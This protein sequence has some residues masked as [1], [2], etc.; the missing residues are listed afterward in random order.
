VI[1][2]PPGP[3]G[4][5]FLGIGVAFA[6]D[7]F[8]VLLDTV[9][10]YGDIAFVRAAGVPVY[11]LSHPSDIHAVLIEKHRLYNKD[12][13]ARN[14]IPVFGR[15]LLINEGDSWRRQRA[16]VVPAFHRQHIEK[17]AG[18]V[19]D[20]TERMLAGWRDGAV[21]AVDQAMM[22]LS[23]D[24]VLSTLFGGDASSLAPRL[25]AALSDMSPFF[26]S[27]AASVPSLRWLPTRSNRSLRRG[28]RALNQIVDD[29]IARG[30]SSS[31]PS[32]MISMLLEARDTNGHGMTDEQLHDE[33]KSFFLASTDTTA[34]ALTYAFHLLGNHRAVDDRLAN[35]VFGIL[36]G[37]PPALSDLAALQ[38]TEQV[39]KE[40]LRLY[41]PAWIITR[42]PI[43][44]DEIRG[45]RIPLGSTVAMS[46][47]SVHRDAR[48]FE[49]P[50][51][52]HPERWT[53]TFEE[54]LP[55]QAFF[56][57]G[58]GPHRCIGATFALMELRLIVATIVGRFRLTA[59]SDEPLQ[60]R[61]SITARPAQRI[62]MRIQ[63]R[64]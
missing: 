55:A 21:I 32:H 24:V 25:E 62:R 34:L 39:I 22:R 60:L 12:R 58:A 29:V 51:S 10:K 42:E 47:Y 41:P 11:L 13:F 38:F 15:G 35:E 2:L 31:R 46:P 1:A 27:V 7:P 63:A 50:E 61:A 9:R 40:T 64:Q 48:F 33:V 43:E 3:R 5:P 20:A 16:L 26:E 18:T 28:V 52:F 8:G 44:D 14:I 19:V 54:Q 49:E 37:R 45:Y 17:M 56:P 59:E 30:R 4:L 23:L 36:G 6:R 53:R 57:F